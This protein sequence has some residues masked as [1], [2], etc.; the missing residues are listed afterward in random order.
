[1]TVT[2]REKKQFRQIAHHLDAVI[3]VGDQG[4]T[5]GVVNETDRALID[6]ELIKVKL[7]CGEREDRRLAAVQLTEACN[8]QLIHSIGKVVVLYRAN[9]KA[10]PKLSNLLRYS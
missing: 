2:A 7:A 1:M 5:E 4:V 10:N 3:I 8:A 6:H 9:P